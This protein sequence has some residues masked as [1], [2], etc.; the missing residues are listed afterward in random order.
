M[1]SP[2]LLMM[3]LAYAAYKI[4]HHYR[5]LHSLADSVDLSSGEVIDTSNNFQVAIGDKVLQDGRD[6]ELGDLDL[7]IF[8]NG[9]IQVTVGG[10]TSGLDTVVQGTDD[11]GNRGS[12]HSRVD[13]ST[14]GMSHDVQDLGTENGASE[15]QRSDRFGVDDISRN[16]ANE[17]ITEPLVEDHL[18]GH[19]TV[20]A[21]QKGGKWGLA[22]LEFLQAVHVTVGCHNVAGDEPCVSCL[23]GLDA[24][25]GRGSVHRVCVGAHLP[26]VRR[27]VVA[28]GRC[29]VRATAR[30]GASGTTSVHRRVA[31]SALLRSKALGES[32]GYQPVP[33]G[34]GGRALGGGTSEGG[35][36]RGV[37]TGIL[38]GGGGGGTLEGG[39][40]HGDRDCCR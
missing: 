32:S 25:C 12:C 20:G 19:A 17:Q 13:G 30:M 34:H 4:L 35:C 5:Q 16:A 3:I 31:R 33:T 24:L 7:D 10:I 39:R 8:S 23:E 6:S 1:M 14:A 15:F 21:R 38:L 2:F 40:E 27:L 9:S 18:D 28:Q 37:S 36:D 11:T 22:T 26:D 29:T